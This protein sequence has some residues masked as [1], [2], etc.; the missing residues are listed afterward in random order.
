MF[1]PLQIGTF[2]LKYPF[3]LTPMAGV[4]NLAVRKI[5]RQYGCQLAFLE[6]VNARSLC[7]STNKT[8]KILQTDA[9]DH[10]LGVQ[11]LGSEEKYL[12]TAIQ[13]LRQNYKFEIL[14]LNAAC[15][16]RKITSRGEGA[17]LLKDP[18]KMRD[19]LKVMVKH[20]PVPVT[21]KLRLGWDNC[22]QAADIAKYAQDSGI[23]MI[24]VHGRTK[25][26]SYSGTVNY[27]AIRKIKKA[28]QIPV[29]GSGDVFNAV[30]AKKMFTETGC[31]AV[32]IARGSWGNPWIYKQIQEIMTLNKVET[33]PDLELITKTMKEHLDLMVSLYGQEAGTIEFRKFYIW[34]TFGFIKVRALRSKVPKIKTRQQMLDLIDEFA[35]CGGKHTNAQIIVKS[36]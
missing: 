24:C 22:D 25:K 6:M 36:E 32:A 8:L 4:T 33:V 28:V 34:Y 16:Q 9:C 19:L 27:E 2:T 29:T 5:N 35:L 1:K 3:Y 7:G 17:A 13:W 20:S 30:A 15:P 10:A 18:K 23:A 14:D 11:L 31:D 26:Q 12:I 21:V